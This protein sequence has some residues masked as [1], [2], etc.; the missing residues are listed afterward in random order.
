[1][2]SRA[3]LLGH[4]IHPMLIVTSRRMRTRA[5]RSC[6]VG[7]FAAVIFI[8]HIATACGAY[9]ARRDP[10]S[11]GAVADSL[12]HVVVTSREA[13]FTFPVVDEQAVPWPAAT[14]VTTPVGYAWAVRTEG[15]ENPVALTLMVL[16]DE[17]GGIPAFASLDAVLRSGSLRSC[18]HD[19]LWWCAVDVRGT[20]RA[21]GRRAV[22]DLRDSTLVAALRAHR[23]RVAEFIMDRFDR[24][25]LRASAMINYVDP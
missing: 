11:P 18:R 25:V 12:P 13:V 16:P 22:L 19:G 4:S 10:P 9:G 17:G 23:P 8:A 6:A 14:A 3:K 15:Y 7:M 20:A 21:E 5:G 24:R 2:K 1:M